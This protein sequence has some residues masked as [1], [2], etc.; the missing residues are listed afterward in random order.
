MGIIRGISYENEKEHKESVDEAL[1]RNEFKNI[2]IE[3]KTMVENLLNYIP[4]YR[5]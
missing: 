3:Y 5:S 2:P 1:E 4:I